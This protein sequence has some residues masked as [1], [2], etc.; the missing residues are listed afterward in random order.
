MPAIRRPGAAGPMLRGSL[1]S[2]ASSSGIWSISVKVTEGGE[3]GQAVAMLPRR[4][5][6]AKARPRA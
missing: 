6:T 3:Q 5:M 2:G 1:A 4:S